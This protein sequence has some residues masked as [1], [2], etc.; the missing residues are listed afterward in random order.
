MIKP[1]KMT[2]EVLRWVARKPATVNYPTVKAIKPAGFRGKLEFYPEKCIN[3]KL[4]MRDCPALAIEITKVAEK[5]FD[6]Q[7]SFDRC[8]FCGQCVETCPKKALGMTREF[9]LASAD[10]K[11]LKVTTRGSAPTPDQ[12]P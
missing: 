12:K 1:G 3:C 4:C 9:E 7:F 11:S 5:Q 2:R 6:C 8:L 10:R